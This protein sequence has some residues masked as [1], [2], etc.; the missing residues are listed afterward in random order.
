M[1]SPAKRRKTNSHV[2]TTKPVRGLDFFFGKQTNKDSKVDNNSGKNKP[3]EESP[4]II[5]ATEELT[6]EQL[7]RKL[8]DEWNEIDNNAASPNK[9]SPKQT[10][11]EVL[12]EDLEAGQSDISLGRKSVSMEREDL[13]AEEI[14]VVDSR[15]AVKPKNTLSLQTGADAEDEICVTLPF[16]QSPLTFDPDEF[17]PTLR[18]TL[19]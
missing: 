15:D 3:L 11:D 13:Y 7:A 17:L 9:P 1:N 14:P 2:A 18:S 10:T 16:D 5:A 19:R 8:Q 6:D 12:E 4:D